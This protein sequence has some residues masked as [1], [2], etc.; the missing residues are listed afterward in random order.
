MNIKFTIV[1]V[2]LIFKFI[3][4]FISNSKAEIKLSV[5]EYYNDEKFFSKIDFEDES[6]FSK[7]IAL[8]ENFNIDFDPETMKLPFNYLLNIISTHPGGYLT[9]HTSVGTWI[10]TSKMFKF[11]PASFKEILELPITMDLKP[12]ELYESEMEDLCDVF[13]LLNERFDKSTMEKICSLPIDYTKSPLLLTSSTDRAASVESSFL[14]K[15]FNVVVSY[16]VHYFILACLGALSVFLLCHRISPSARRDLV[17]D[18]S[19]ILGKGSHGTVVFEGKFGSRSVAVKRLLKEYYNLAEQ[20]IDL[21]IR[22]DHHSNIVSYYTKE[23][24]GQFIYIALEKC[25]TNLFDLVNRG[26]ESWDLKIRYIRDTLIGLAYLHKNSIVHRDLKP[27]NILVGYQNAAKISDMALGK[28]LEDSQS[29]FSGRDV[30]SLGYQAPEVLRGERMTNKVDIFSFGC[31]VYFVLTDG[32]HPFGGMYERNQ[33]ISNNHK[34]ANLLAKREHFLAQHFVDYALT[35]NIDKRPSAEQL[36]GHPIFWNP[37]KKLK[38][39][40]DVSDYLEFF[41]G[42]CQ[43]I[44]LFNDFKKSNFPFKDWQLILGEHWK[45]ELSFHNYDN[46][47]IQHLLRFI[48]NKKHHYRDLNSKLQEVVGA[49]PDGFLNYFTQKFPQLLPHCYTFASQYL[50]G[51]ESLKMYLSQK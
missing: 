34:P 35:F 16:K 10:F 31:I 51:V 11:I 49:L 47:S 6:E 41:N 2:I 45:N 14:T 28:F 9:Y 19:K 40:L 5:P 42:D 13:K 15:L 3:S 12:Y 37:S 4:C 7:S 8:F 26:I 43:L 44:T 30:G 29:Y 23:N 46:D 27:Q 22:S 1:L 18:E 48:R 24:D 25:P 38:F 39:L 21:L 36:L 50:K 20:E 33:R 17:V 32:N